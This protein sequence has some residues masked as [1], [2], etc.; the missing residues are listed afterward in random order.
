MHVLGLCLSW[1]RYNEPVRE[2]SG[3]VL[4]STKPQEML[5]TFTLRSLADCHEQDAQDLFH[6]TAS[7]T[8]SRSR[9]S[10]AGAPGPAPQ[11]HVLP[12]VLLEASRLADPLKIRRSEPDVQKKRCMLKTPNVT[13]VGSD[14]YSCDRML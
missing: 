5:K 12:S 4:E 2:D 10:A 11:E 1:R 9:G 6:G 3:V 13:K 7:A 8:L 14:G